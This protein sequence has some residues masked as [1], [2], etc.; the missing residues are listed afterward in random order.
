M[1]QSI[2]D[3]VCGELERR[4]RFDRLEARGTVRLALKAAG[5]DSRG[6]EVDQMKV[7]LERLM[8]GELLQRGVEDADDVSRAL[9]ASL[10][11]F[12]GVANSTS[13]EAVFRRLA[14]A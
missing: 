6:V 2:F 13:P 9:A 5:L 4:T 11:V 10:A 7:V 12:D 1:T 14:R 3:H 8:P